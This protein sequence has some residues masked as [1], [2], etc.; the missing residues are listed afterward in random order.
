MPVT[1]EVAAVDPLETMLVNLLAVREGPFPAT[2]RQE[3][4]WL[5]MSRRRIGLR[6]R[7]CRRHRKKQYK[8]VHGYFLLALREVLEAPAFSSRWSK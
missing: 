2:A 6:Q 7:H 8:L 5:E 4:L 1:Q 3:G